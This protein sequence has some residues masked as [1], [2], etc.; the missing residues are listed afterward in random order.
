MS[1]HTKSAELGQE[2]SLV[3]GRDYSWQ[4]RCRNALVN[5]IDSHYSTDPGKFE[6]AFVMEVTPS[7]GKTVGSLTTGRPASNAV[8]RGLPSTA[9][10]QKMPAPQHT[11]VRIA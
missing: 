2:V 10:K 6:R 7:G 11:T 4:E 1:G 8:V 5:N 3:F 9:A